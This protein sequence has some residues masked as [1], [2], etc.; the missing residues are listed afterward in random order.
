MAWKEK[1]V[2]KLYY[3]IGEV[4][5]M[6]GINAS[7]L[8]YWEKEFDILKPKKNG[9]GDR[10]Y[11]KEEIEK[12]KLINHL[13]RERGFTTEGARAQLKSGTKQVEKTAQIV[14]KLKSIKGFLEQ[15]KEELG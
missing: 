15:L 11:T 1:P 6:L 13:I 5:E 3:S 10:F 8:R 2:E 4:V 7:A 14:N 12:V 9:K